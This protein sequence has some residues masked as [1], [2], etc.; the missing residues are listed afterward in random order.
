MPPRGF[1][2]N[3]EVI[4]PFFQELKSRVLEKYEPLKYTGNFERVFFFRYYTGYNKLTVRLNAPDYTQYIN[5]PGRPPGPVP[6]QVI[7]DWVRNKPIIPRDNTSPENVAWA[8]KRKI[9]L[10]GIDVPNKFNKGNLLQ[11]IVDFVESGEV[12]EM[13]DA[14]SENIRDQAVRSI[15][16][17]IDESNTAKTKPVRKRTRPARRVKTRA[18]KR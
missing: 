12:N 9:E 13:L 17:S 15:I 16:K 6:Y 2:V 1:R 18:K 14:M 4:R 3:K 10:D 11:P 5:P 7:L 8:I